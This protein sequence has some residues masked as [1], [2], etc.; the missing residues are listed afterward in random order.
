MALKRPGPP[1]STLEDNQFLSLDLYAVFI[2]LL[3]EYTGGIGLDPVIIKTM[4]FPASPVYAGSMPP[5]ARVDCR[6]GGDFE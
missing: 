6:R 3:R 1:L 4:I 5:W 2:K